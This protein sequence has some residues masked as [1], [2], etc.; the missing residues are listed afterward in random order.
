MYCSS[1]CQVEHEKFIHRQECNKKPLPQV[2]VVCTKM[3]LTAVEL[4]GSIGSLRELLDN[5]EHPTVF[6]YDLSHPDD[7]DYKR[8]LLLVVNSM[9]KSEHS[10]IVISEKMKSTFDF[11]PFDELWKT[12]DEREFLIETF[13]NQLRI[14]NTNQL[15]MGEH[16]MET[17]DDPNSWSV[18]TIGG[19][20]C[21]F[22][23][24]FNHSCDANVKRTCI[25][26]KIAFVVAA[27]VVAGE[28]L[29]LSYGYS[30]C[31]VSKK[32][33]QELLKRFSFICDCKACEKDFPEISELPTF[34]RKFVEPKFS[35]MTVQE[36]I[37]EFR[38]NCEYIEK[39]FSHHPSYE[40]TTLMIH[41]DHL[42]Y[43]IARVSY[44]G[45]QVLQ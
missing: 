10:K 9:A 8:N 2:L 14:H 27:P 4:A 6:D 34:D 37:E 36:A 29:F 45:S 23:S 28:Q 16:K 20:L 15:E 43:Q 41:N 13:H 26:N 39:Y 32:E 5:S 1:E 44:D 21:P 35:A 17:W 19:G 30:S 40:T 18:K 22:A 24:L 31:R 3:L 33:R 25:D 7:P 42:L 38:K 12:D 11:P